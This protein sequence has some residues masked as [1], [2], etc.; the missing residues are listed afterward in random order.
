MNNNPFTPMH[1]SSKKLPLS[2][3]I[4]LKKCNLE[5]RRVF[6]SK[7]SDQ[8]LNQNTKTT[9]LRNLS[10]NQTPLSLTIPKNQKYNY[11]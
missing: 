9:H 10:K 7:I 4:S 6:E 11:K 8:Q 5:V 2:Q 1:P 3:K